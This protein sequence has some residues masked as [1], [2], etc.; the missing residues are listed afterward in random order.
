MTPPTEPTSDPGPNAPPA[1]P[2]PLTR[3]RLDRMLGGV[4]GGIA[5]TYGFDAALVRVA[6]VVIAIATAGAGAVGYVIA[7]LLIPE[8]GAD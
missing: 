1:P 4:A 5:H 7:W 2:R 6:I 8:A 3:S